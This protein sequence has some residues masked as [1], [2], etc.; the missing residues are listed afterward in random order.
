MPSRKKPRGQRVEQY[1]LPK[2]WKSGDKVGYYLEP[3]GD[4]MKMAFMGDEPFWSHDG[5]WTVDA[6]TYERRIIT[7][8]WHKTQRQWIYSQ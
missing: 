6:L 2:Q 3:G 8:V 1:S 7:L 5:Y 4:T